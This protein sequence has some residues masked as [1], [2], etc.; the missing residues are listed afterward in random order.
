MLN[1]LR[2]ER[3]EF[4]IRITAFFIR[5]NAFYVIITRNLSKFDDYY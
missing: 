2:V 3:E 5:I 1:S 4:Q